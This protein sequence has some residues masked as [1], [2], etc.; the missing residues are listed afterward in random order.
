MKQVEAIKKAKQAYIVDLNPQSNNIN[1]RYAVYVDKIADQLCPLWPHID[2]KG[3][4]KLLPLQVY[5]KNKNYP[6]YHFVTNG[7]HDLATMLR[8]INPKIKVFRPFFGA[9]VHE[10][11]YQR[12]A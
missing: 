1:N 7:E 4:E 2:E 11:D 10:I 6:T 12:Y 3:T 9:H 8:K 5:S